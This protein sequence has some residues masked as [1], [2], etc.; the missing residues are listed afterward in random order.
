MREA[1]L[2]GTT[3]AGA[4]RWTRR[5]PWIVVALVAYAL[6]AGLILVLPVG[7][8]DIVNAGADVLSRV[9]L[10]GFGTGWVEF[11]ANIL[12]F[13]PLG[14]LLTLLLRHHVWGFVLAVALSAAAE[15][16]QFVVPSRQ[17][18]LRDLLA[19]GLGAALGAGLAWLLIV[20]RDRRSDTPA[21]PSE[22]V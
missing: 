2:D 13:V 17:P 1:S 9:G 4:E 19:N 20:R 21:A 12:M 6:A 18:S 3:G 8:G 7:Y 5:R 11:I 14:L 22:P 10:T 16:V 15:L